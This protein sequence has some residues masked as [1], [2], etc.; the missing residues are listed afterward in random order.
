METMLTADSGQADGNFSKIFKTAFAAASPLPSTGKPKGN[1]GFVTFHERSQT[2]V[3][4]AKGLVALFDDLT[5]RSAVDN[6]VAIKESLWESDIDKV[7]EI[8]TIGM[9][10]QMGKIQAYLDAQ[11]LPVLEGDAALVAK[12]LQLG[13]ANTETGRSWGREARKQEKA[14][15][16]LVRVFEE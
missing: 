6:F 2:L 1:Q 9:N 10:V 11:Q 7:A 8:L 15:R 4:S 12:E 13:E 16:R 3:E 14:V 5:E